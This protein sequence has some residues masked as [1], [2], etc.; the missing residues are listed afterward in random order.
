VKPDFRG[1]LR[2]LA[3]EGVDVIIIGGVAASLHGSAHATY[4]LDVVYSREPQNL[5]RLIRALASLHPYL[6]GAPAGLP[7]RWDTDTLKSGLNFTLTTDLGSFD[8]LGEVTGG[9]RYEDLL[10]HTI[11]I[12]AFGITC[13]SVTLR[14]LIQLKRAAGR[15]RDLNAIAELEA[16]LE[17]Q[18]QK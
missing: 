8:A 12:Q 11:E 1:L 15:P 4:D 5:D 10:P 2:T 16:L 6:R 7:F 9:G 3:G 17:E 13:R 18:E 14:K